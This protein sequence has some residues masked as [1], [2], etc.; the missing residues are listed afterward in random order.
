MDRDKRWD[1]VQKAWEAMVGGQGAFAADAVLAVR[2]AYGRG[3]TDEFI[4]PTV[5][6]RP[7]ARLEA[8]GET[9]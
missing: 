8:L 5:L 1:R 2:E 4:T 6:V 9:T 7:V 3:E